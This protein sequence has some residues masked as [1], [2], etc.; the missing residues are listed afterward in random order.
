L[1]ATVFG[2]ACERPPAGLRRQQLL[3]DPPVE[4][5]RGRSI[6]V[7][8]GEPQ[9][10]ASRRRPA[11]VR[12][13]PVPQDPE[14]LGVAEG[15]AELVQRQGAAPRDPVI[16]QQQAPRI[17]RE[18]IAGQP[19]QAPIRPSGALPRRRTAAGLRPEPTGAAGE[20]GREPDIRPPVRRHAGPEP[21]ER[22]EPRQEL[23][24]KPSAA[25]VRAHNRE[26]L[27]VDR[28]VREAVRHR[29]RARREREGTEPAR[30]ATRVPSASGRAQRRRRALPIRTPTP[31][32]RHRPVRGASQAR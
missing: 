16:E 24:G 26:H 25:M 4:A 28:A 6:G 13:A 17:R 3:A 20:P 31:G 30:R 22:A 21:L 29:Q 11:A 32:P 18:D 7:L 10:P 2:R 5:P 12:P 14:E 27:R 23:V 1:L 19:L 9:E 15:A 8:L